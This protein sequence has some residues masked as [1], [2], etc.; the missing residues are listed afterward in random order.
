MCVL[1]TGHLLHVTVANI[2]TESNYT[3]FQRVINTGP[4]GYKHTGL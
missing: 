1:D 2:N 4:R 3:L